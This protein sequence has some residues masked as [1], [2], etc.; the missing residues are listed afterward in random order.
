MAGI[1]LVVRPSV[2]SAPSANVSGVAGL[3]AVAG[4]PVALAVP[5]VGGVPILVRPSFCLL[6]CYCRRP[7][8]VVRGWLS[9][10]I[11]SL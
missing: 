6:S 5:D 4:V 3:P 11:V 8:T 2:G 1:S 10:C 7:C 9:S